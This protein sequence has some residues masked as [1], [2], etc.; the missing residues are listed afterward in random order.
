MFSLRQ[1]ITGSGVAGCVAC[2]LFVIGCNVDTRWPTRLR[3]HHLTGGSRPEY[4][5]ITLADQ[6]EVDLVEQVAASRAAYHDNLRKLYA[7]YEQNGYEAKRSW[8]ALELSGL[9][10]VKQFAYLMD[11]EV[12]SG[13]LA[14]SET[15]PEA[16]KLYQEGLELM[17]S[18]GHGVPGVYR[19]DRMIEAANV[20][21]NLIKQYPSSDKIDDAAFQCGEIHKE[22][23]PDQELIAVSWYER[24][25]TWNPSIPHP[26]KFNAAV[27]YDYRLHDR[28]RALELYHDVANDPAS[29]PAD[30]R[31][32]ARRIQELTDGR[33]STAASRP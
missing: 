27:V 11:A 6:R 15:I 26:A 7:Y 31:Y 9:R 16:D 10:T 8:A 3:S 24:A 18:G 28:D 12:P 19:E 4:V 5:D 30:A 20:F 21:R 23:L 17:R 22:Y 33:A 29:T 2:L 14:A 13:R 32:A 1:R 25:W